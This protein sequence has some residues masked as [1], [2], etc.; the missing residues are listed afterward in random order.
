MNSETLPVCLLLSIELVFSFSWLNICLLILSHMLPSLLVPSSSLYF[1]RFG[2][3]SPLDFFF[4]I[5]AFPRCKS[6]PPCW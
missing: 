2:A 4:N 5:L 1:P 6:L 3:Y